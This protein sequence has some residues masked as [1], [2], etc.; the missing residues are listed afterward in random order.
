MRVDAGARSRY[1]VGTVL[2]PRLTT[3]TIGTLSPHEY[4]DVLAETG[5]GMVCI[6]DRCGRIVLF[7]SACERATGFAAADVVDRD[8]RETVIPPDE[9]EAFGEF[10]SV[11]SKTSSPRPQVG[12]WATADGGRRLIAWSNRPILDEAEEITG[13]VTV[14]I[15]LTE[16]QEVS[17]QLDRLHGEL[18]RRLVELE[19]LASEQ[20]ALRRVATLVAGEA[21]AELVL[22]VI[23]TEVAKLTLARTAAVVRYGEAGEGVVAGRWS[24]TDEDVFGIGASIPLTEDSAVGR[25]YAKGEPARVDDYGD[26]DG[27][28]SSTLRDAGYVSAAAAPV[29][30]AGRAWGAVV[31]VCGSEPRLP[32]G[33]EKRLA[34]F[35]GLLSL[36]ISSA[37]ARE[38]L[39]ASRGRLVAAADAERRRFERDLHDGAQQRLVTLALNLS[40]ARREV[41]DD[42]KLG[43][44]L[45]RAERDAR[46]AIAELRNL[47]SGLH[48]PILSERGLGPA[49]AAL[50][51]RSHLE[52]QVEVPMEERFDPTLE[53]AAY[54]VVSESL[55]NAAK[56]AA[57]ERVVVRA[58]REDQELVVSIA[59]D[60]RG[61]ANP[62]RGTGLVGLTDRVE[63]LRGALDISSSESSGTVVRAY[64][65]L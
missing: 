33:V 20:A 27:E 10:L 57:C 55:T 53:V 59:D 47:A 4:V 2:T 22:E 32:E 49:I 39:I 45:G 54:Y 26:G 11:L 50:A 12:H 7:D 3:P 52:V 8:A 43:E 13:L 16:R 42:S 6:L 63:A 31:A 17:E 37:E 25:V 46:E 36:A 44:L 60:G 61:G 1:R 15:D 23:S 65:P 29:T 30:V 62:R 40:M 35:A 5:A 34:S 58:R 48:P 28:V 18:E 14:G 56:H 24:D 64:F 41:D 19:R 38:Q 51:R 9:A 21:S